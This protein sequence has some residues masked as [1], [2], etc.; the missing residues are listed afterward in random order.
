MWIFVSFKIN[1]DTIAKTLC[2]KK[3]IKK[4]TCQGKCHLKKQL[5]GAD[6]E[7][8]KQAQTNSKDKAEILYCH[9]AKPNYFLKF[10]DIYLSKLNTE[11]KNS[12]HNYSFI[13]SIFQPPQL[14]LN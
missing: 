6:K 11:Y 8:Q 10:A 3:E 12:L 4:N 1:Q 2:E 7:E 5:E 13:T 14:N 9:F